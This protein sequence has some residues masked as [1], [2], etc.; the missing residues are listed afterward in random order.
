MSNWHSWQRDFRT[1]LNST[2]SD[3]TPRSLALK[4]KA[5]AGAAAAFA[6]AP[7]AAAGRPSSG[8]LTDSPDAELDELARDDSESSDSLL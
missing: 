3:K 8:T 7:A 2:E 5:L 1:W 4:K 6:V